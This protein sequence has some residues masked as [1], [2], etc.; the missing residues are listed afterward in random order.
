MN[1]FDIP[2][3]FSLDKTLHNKKWNKE[4]KTKIV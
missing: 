4:F 2:I 1:T 3:I